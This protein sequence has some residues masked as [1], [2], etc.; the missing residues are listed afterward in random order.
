M[1]S[2][3]ESVNT[4]HHI[5]FNNSN[6]YHKIMS[7]CPTTKCWDQGDVSLRSSFSGIHFPQ[8]LIFLLRWDSMIPFHALIFPRTRTLVQCYWIYS[9]KNDWHLARRLQV[10]PVSIDF[11]F[12]SLSTSK[13]KIFTFCYFEFFHSLGVSGRLATKYALRGNLEVQEAKETL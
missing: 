5:L 11:T 1:C 6:K 9:W 3:S 8:V 2:E 7:P 10:R 4:K 12:E 13:H